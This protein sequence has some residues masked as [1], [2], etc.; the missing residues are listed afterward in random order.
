M[1]SH[2]PTI[3][4]AIFSQIFKGSTSGCVI[5]EPTLFSHA[6]DWL[7]GHQKLVTD[8]INVH[9]KLAFFPA[10]IRA[11]TQHFSQALRGNPDNGCE[12][13]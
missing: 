7:F 1:P 10:I 9:N 2:S 5:N 4:R 3:C 6:Q 11:V 8:A 12:G 13:D